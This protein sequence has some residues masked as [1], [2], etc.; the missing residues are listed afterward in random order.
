MSIKNFIFIVLPLLFF[1]FGCGS[2]KTIELPQSRTLPSWYTT[3]PKTDKTTLYSSGEG[4]NRDEAI[5]DALN[6]M[7]STLSVSIASQFNSKEV[8]REGSQ[9]SYQSNVTN[10]IQS[11][12]KKIRISQYELLNAEELGFRKY[13]VLIKSDKKKLFES[14]KTELNQKFE[15]IDKELEIMH[16][17]NVIKQLSTY[18][19]A[20]STISDVPNTLIVMNVLDS[21]FDAG[22][23]LKR[24]KTINS[25]YLKLLS[26]ISFSIVARDE[27][28][29]LI[30]PISHGLGV[31]KLQI[32][33][34]TDDKH[35]VIF[36]KSDIQKA[37][38]YGFILARSAIEISVK[39]YRGTVIGSNKLN[40]SGQSIQSYEAAKEGVAVKLN[41]MIKKEGIGKVLGLDL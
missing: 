31:K 17:Q 5:A 27:S 8:V 1:L 4:K 35:V 3:P 21:S 13:I 37:L 30:S 34:S 26:T 14:L 24:V 28:K 7:A 32:K 6:M 22:D 41:E 23:Y 18:K 11:D 16:G 38:A 12:V 39:D 20:T 9:N 29:N 15:L 25:T 40:I 33:N 36:V 2:S 10:E 19:K